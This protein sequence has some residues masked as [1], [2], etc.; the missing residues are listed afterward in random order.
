MASDYNRL[1]EFC[2]RG[3][4]VTESY[5]FGNSRTIGGRFSKEE[6]ERTGAAFFLLHFAST[7]PE[8]PDLRGATLS[9]LEAQEAQGACRV[10]I[11]MEGAEARCVD[12]TCSRAGFT[13]MRYRGMSVRNMYDT[14]EYRALMERQQ[15]VL[16]EANLCEKQEYSLPDGF[17]LET[18]SYFA[19]TRES[20]LFLQKCTLRREG[21]PFYEYLSS[22][23][24]VRPFRDWIRHRNG[25]RYYPFHEDLYGISYLD[26]ETGEAYHYIPEGWQHDMSWVL[27]ESFIITDIHYDPTTSLIAYGGCFWGGSEDVMVGDFS[28]PSNASL[29]WIGMQDQIDPDYERYDG[30]DFEK[31]GD[32][33]LILRCN[34][35]R[36][37]M[38]IGEISRLLGGS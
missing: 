29:C 20:R 34:S 26:L 22:D 24:H 6:E 33:K 12:F 13:P 28:D 10:V 11:R 1:K 17:T 3:S 16:D 37:G 18:A 4:L 9:F 23:S 31:W 36:V 30:L 25:R 21:A 5:G 7:Q 8:L 19:Q 32:E 27:G 35:Q 14:K 2:F 15:P 38:R